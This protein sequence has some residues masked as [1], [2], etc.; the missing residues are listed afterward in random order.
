MPAAVSVMEEQD[1]T[2]FDVDEETDVAAAA[3][4]GANMLAEP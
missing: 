2:F 4:G 1:I 3:E